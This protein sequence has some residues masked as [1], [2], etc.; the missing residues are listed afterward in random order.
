MSFDTELESF[1]NDDQLRLVDDPIRFK[2]KLQIGDDAFKLLSLAGNL[3]LMVSAGTIGATV[4]ASSFVASSVFGSGLLY[5][6]GIVAA[7]TPIGWVLGA[8]VGA[9]GAVYGLK[10][11]L[12]DKKRERVLVIPKYINTPIDLLAL[13]LSELMIPLALKVSLADGV[14]V[15]KERDKILGYFI[16]DWGLNRVLI[17]QM[18]EESLVH[19]NDL[20]YDDLVSDINKLTT[21]NKDCNRIEICNDLIEFLEEIAS[22]DGEICE[23]EE[24]QIHYLRNKLLP[25]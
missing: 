4:A 19:V 12:S 5:S 11:A 17:S 20:K 8:G 1:Y 13:R 6:L 2:A 25:G 22:S 3:E 9:A 23:R 10:K 21:E 24:I 7:V 14:I 18:I 15:Q 16:N